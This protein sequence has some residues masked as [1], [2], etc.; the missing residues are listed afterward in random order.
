MATILLVV[1]YIALLRP[2]RMELKLPVCMGNPHRGCCI[3]AA[4]ESAFGL[5][6]TLG[7]L[8][9]AVWRPVRDRGYFHRRLWLC[10]GKM[11]V[12]NPL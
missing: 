4:D 2:W 7:C 10:R 9:T 3:P 12:G 11:G 8:W 1:I 5:G 6:D